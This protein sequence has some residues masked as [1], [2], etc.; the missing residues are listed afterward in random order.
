MA[1]LSLSQEK[2]SVALFCFYSE[3]IIFII[4]ACTSRRIAKYGIQSLFIL[5]NVA[6]FMR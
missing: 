4:L 3:N 2:I 5:K 1:S 6:A